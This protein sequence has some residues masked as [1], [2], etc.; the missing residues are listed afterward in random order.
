MASAIV[1]GALAEGTKPEHTGQL[2]ASTGLLNLAAAL[3][4]FHYLNSMAVQRTV[5]VSDQCPPW[6]QCET[7]P[8]VGRHQYVVPNANETNRLFL[9]CPYRAFC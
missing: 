5:L 3:A 7:Y 6:L 1:H 8:H 9:P 4:Q 2:P